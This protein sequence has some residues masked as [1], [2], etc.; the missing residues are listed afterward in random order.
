MTPPR[1]SSCSIVAVA[2]RRVDA[3]DT[4]TTRFPHGNVDA[5]R[6]AL[7]RTLENA[8]AMLVV[9]SAACGS[10]L[11]ALDAASVLGIRVR[12]ILPFAPEVFRETSV[13]DRP[14][15]AYWGNLYDRLIAERVGAG[16][17]SFS[18]A[19]ETILAPMPQPTKPSSVRHCW[20]RARRRHG[21]A[22]SP[23]SPGKARPAPP[24]MPQ[25]I[26]AVRHC[27]ADLRSSRSRPSLPF[28]MARCESEGLRCHRRLKSE[29]NWN[30]LK[31][32]VEIA[33]AKRLP[34][35]SLFGK[36]AKAGGLLAYGPNLGEMFRRCGEYVGRI[37]QGAKPSDLPI[38]R[39][40]KFDLVINLK[41]AAAL[42]FTVPPVLLATADEVIE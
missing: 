41:T 25:T 23:S 9:A 35:I 7:S 17:S 11:L 39:P 2:G 30:S 37:L 28:D 1:G 4:Q 15:P 19:T 3:A 13:V 27:S 40:E 22:L 16:T 12:I 10:D 26:S 20:P 21:R 42:G 6:A 14:Q 18:I 38:Q 5:V 8:A 33:L 34:L 32:I 31:Q 29:L 24:T 36:F